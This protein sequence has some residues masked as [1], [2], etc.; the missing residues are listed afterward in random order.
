MTYGG[1][2]K[3]GHDGLNVEVFR[4]SEAHFLICLDQSHGFRIVNLAL[5]DK[6]GTFIGLRL[7]ATEK[8]IPDC[9]E[10][11]QRYACTFTHL[12]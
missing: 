6:P 11:V 5:S 1:N 8:G 3:Q 9:R 4:V 7:L 2:T 12:E 10:V